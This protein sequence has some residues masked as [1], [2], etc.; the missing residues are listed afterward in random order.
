MP[1]IDGIETT[2]RMREIVGPNTLIIII[3]AYDWGAIEKNARAAGA[4]AFLAKPIF[5]STLY[6]ALLS[7]TGIEKAIMVPSSREKLHRP[8]L[9]GRHVLLVEDNDINR[10]IAMELLKMT[11]ITVDYA[12]N[13]Q[14]AADR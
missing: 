1:D 8:D 12:N 9:A 2:R 3:T 10:E 4:N 6:N 14:E 13:G 11:D 5:A 7:M